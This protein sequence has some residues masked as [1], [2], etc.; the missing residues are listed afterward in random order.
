MA[1]ELASSSSRPHSSTPEYRSLRQ[2]VLGIGM[3]VL[4]LAV[5]LNYFLFREIVPLRQQ[6]NNLG[7]FLA[8]HESTT[9]PIMRSF[10]DQLESFAR[11]NPDFRPILGKYI[12]I[13]NAVNLPAQPASATAP[14]GSAPAGRR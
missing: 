10:R 5:A 7:G 2:F 14:V 11:S 4:I 1:A 13:T 9:V 8:N 6:I 12:V 3:S